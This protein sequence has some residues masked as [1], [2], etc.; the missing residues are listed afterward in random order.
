MKNQNDMIIS[1]VAIVVALI[2]LGV[3]YGTKPD[4][5][6]PAGSP[7]VDTAAPTLGSVEVP[8]TNG[9]GGS[10]NNGGRAA[11]GGGGAR[12]G[13]GFAPS[14]V[15]GAGGGG[16]PPANTGFGGAGGNGAPRMS[17]VNAAG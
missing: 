9:V 17:G 1:I 6:V 2:A 12:G 15:Q 16:A 10:G 7:S 8:R 5:K 3:L 13:G 4:P 11:G 14:G